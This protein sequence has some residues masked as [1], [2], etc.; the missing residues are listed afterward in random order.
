MFP[1]H[2]F[3]LSPNIEATALG[4]CPQLKFPCTIILLVDFEVIL[5]NKT[6]LLKM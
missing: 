4:V 1:T 3:L 2:R 6:A 5:V